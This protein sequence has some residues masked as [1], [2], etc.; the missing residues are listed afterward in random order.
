MEHLTELFT[1][2]ENR[3]NNYNW[4]RDTV[5]RLLK[6]RQEITEKQSTE[7]KNLGKDDFLNKL[8]PLVSG[9][10]LEEFFAYVESD[11]QEDACTLQLS[12]LPVWQEMLDDI[13]AGRLDVGQ[14]EPEE[15]IRNLSNDKL[16]RISNEIITQN[17]TAYENLGK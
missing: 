6:F 2:A 7:L 8:N 16:L 10:D 15:R 3:F 9:I 1:R 12:K 4:T 11:M 17:K 13:E 5:C 14:K